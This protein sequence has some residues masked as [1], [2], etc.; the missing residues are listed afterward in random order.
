MLN[1][2]TQTVDNA[3]HLFYCVKRQA[4]VLETVLILFF[5]GLFCALCVFLFVCHSML[6]SLV[7]GSVCALK[8]QMLDEE[9][10]MQVL[11]KLVKAAAESA[12]ESPAQAPAPALAPAPAPAPAPASAPATQPEEAAAAA[13]PRWCN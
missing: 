3:F 7:F 4:D 9:L 10:I 13:S 1:N 2:Q 11:Q 12:G 6:K 5:V 8:S